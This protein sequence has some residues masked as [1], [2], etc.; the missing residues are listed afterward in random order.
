MHLL[1]VEGAPRKPRAA[2]REVALAFIA[3]GRARHPDATVDTL[4]VW[5][6]ELPP[7]DEAVMEAKYTGLDG[8]ALTPEQQNAWDGVRGNC[9]KIGGHAATTAGGCGSL[10]AWN[11]CPKPEPSVPL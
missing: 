3:A 5:S 2:A 1:H 6:T 7:F 8:Q 10:A 11:R 4:D 9:R